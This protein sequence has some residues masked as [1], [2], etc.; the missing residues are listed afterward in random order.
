MR[1]RYGAA[2]SALAEA[3]AG[4]LAEAGRLAS[5]PA[6]NV[7]VMTFEQNC[8]RS[9]RTS[10]TGEPLTTNELSGPAAHMQVMLLAANPF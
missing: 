8:P 9:S 2:R 4:A 1:S 7:V 10:S 3:P 6:I 5:S